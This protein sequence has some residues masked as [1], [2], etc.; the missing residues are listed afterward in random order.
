MY[1]R[2]FGKLGFDVSTFGFGAMRLKQL[3]NDGGI[4]Y[5]YAINLIRAAID[6]GVNY[7]DTAYVYHGGFSEVAVGRAL[8]DGYRDRVK[9]ATK[10]AVWEAKTPENFEAQLDTSLKRLQTDHIDFYLFHSIEGERW[11]SMGDAVM[12]FMDKMVQKGKVLYPSFSFHDSPEKF[13]TVLD[14]YDWKMAQVQFN[15][16]D[17]YA[18]NNA[19]LEGIEYAGKK[20][21]PIVVM[22]PLRGGALVDPPADVQALYDAFPNKRSAVDWAF[23]YCYDRP[24]VVTVLSGISTMEMLEENLAIFADGKPGSMSQEEHDLIAKVRE[25]YLSR[26]KV[27]CTGC[28]YCMPCPAGVNIPR[29]LRAYDTAS[30]FGDTARLKREY[31][32]I[33]KAGEGQDQCIECGACEAQCPQ[34]ISIIEKLKEAAAAAE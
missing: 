3:P 1:N 13:K 29:I 19:A 30:I 6:K 25:T 21:V 5:D 4:D 15:F 7:V 2:P 23:R 9:L 11:E 20:G 22:E 12:T 10:L 8:Q 18:T 28:R 31:A 27:G 26:T 32:N 17:T 16:L 14:A 24:E 34:K 33:V